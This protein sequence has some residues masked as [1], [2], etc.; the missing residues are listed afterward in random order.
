MKSTKEIR[1]GLL[2]V[3]NKALAFS[4]GIVVRHSLSGFQIAMRVA[5]IS[6]FNV[7]KMVS[8]GARQVLEMKFLVPSDILQ[9]SLVG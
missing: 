1:L 2:S 5:F 3:S 6:L 8:V 9:I 4:A 7:T